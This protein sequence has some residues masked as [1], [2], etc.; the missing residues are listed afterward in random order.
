MD[1]T[2][3]PGTQ[4]QVHRSFTE[5]NDEA[6]GPRKWQNNGY[7][8]ALGRPRWISEGRLLSPLRS[9]PLGPLSWPI[10]HRRPL[11]SNVGYTSYLQLLDGVPKT[12]HH[13]LLRYLHLAM[14]LVMPETLDPREEA[15][16]PL[17]FPV[18]CSCPSTFPNHPSN[19][20]E[21]W[22]LSLHRPPNRSLLIVGKY[23][24]DLIEPQDENRGMALPSSLCLV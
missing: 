8:R 16:E 9:G 15:P 19:A 7:G 13:S 23:G 3:T 18:S 2:R 21:S 4:T 11:T 6:D 17:E 14:A 24:A 22:W 1:D 20:G 5:Y 12:H 10:S